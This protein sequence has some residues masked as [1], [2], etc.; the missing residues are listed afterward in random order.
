VL[1]SCSMHGWFGLNRVVI[2]GTGMCGR[3]RPTCGRS[4]LPVKTTRVELACR[5]SSWCPIIFFQFPVVIR[6]RKC[7]SSIDP[8][9]V[10][11]EHDA[12]W[13]EACDSSLSLSNSLI[14]EICLCRDSDYLFPG[15]AICMIACVFQILLS[16][17]GCTYIIVFYGVER[18]ISLA[19]IS[20]VDFQFSML[21]ARASDRYSLS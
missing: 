20:L 1:E 6:P 13:Q 3:R 15:T 21:C 18:M 10:A 17:R 11:Q 7:F 19:S 12:S 8:G 4:C 5:M 9:V 16:R 14:L 2:P